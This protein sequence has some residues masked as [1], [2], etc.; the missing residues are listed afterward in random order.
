MDIMGV[1][2]WGCRVVGGGGGG[3]E[4]GVVGVMNLLCVN[5]TCGGVIVDMRVVGLWGYEPIVR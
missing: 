4:C 1:G 2:V 5:S 3:W